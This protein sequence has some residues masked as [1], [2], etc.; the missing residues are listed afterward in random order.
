MAARSTTSSTTK[1]CGPRHAAFVNHVEQAT[2]TLSDLGVLNADEAAEL[3]A[4]AEASP[5]GKAGT[6]GYEALFDGTAASL[7]GW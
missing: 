3:N 4:A 5:I 6:T 7:R 2:E 1:A